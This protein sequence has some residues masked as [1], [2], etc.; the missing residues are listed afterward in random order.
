MRF[1]AL[2]QRSR[3]QNPGTLL[4][5][6][7]PSPYLALSLWFALLI[8]PLP[9]NGAEIIPFYTWNQSPLVQ[10]FG[11]PAAE[12]AILL[13][14][15]KAEGVL[16]VDVASNFAHDETSREKILLDSEGFRFT[17]ALRY[18]VAKGIEAGVDIPYVGKGG[19][20]L[21]GFIEGW[22]DFF[23]LPQGGRKQAPRNRLL[24]NYTKDGQN[25]LKID[26]SS[27]GLGDVRLSGGVQLYNDGKA[28]PRAVALRASLKLPT[29]ESSELHGSGSTDFALWLT[30]SDDYG[31]SLGHLTLFGAAGGMVMSD[32]DVLPDQQK[33][34][35][36]FGTLGLGWAPVEWIA[37]KTQVSGH[38]AFY[39]D[40]ELR[41]LS[42]SGLQLLIGGTLFLY[43]KAS[44]DIGVSEDIA[45]NTSPDIAFH[46]ALQ[47][48]F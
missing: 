25:L 48:K 32:G 12:R 28:N 30:A 1:F 40:S 11:L 36:G 5:W 31:L 20:F 33:N 8:L 3:R 42:N 19:G 38:T 46:L 10:I 43:E 27:F 47:R 24:Y 14:A 22:H 45:V 35:A 41:E 39:K 44:L 34:L 7:S 6:S 23:K 21:D 29:G 26:D 13:P 18:G 4:F 16:A 17:L 2:F 9:C 15:G 37:F